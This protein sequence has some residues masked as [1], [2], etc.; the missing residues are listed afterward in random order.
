MKIG[1]WLTDT[2]NEEA[3]HCIVGAVVNVAFG[4]RNAIGLRTT[5]TRY[6]RQAS[7]YSAQFDLFWFAD[8][9]L[10]RGAN[11]HR[12]TVTCVVNNL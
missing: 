12:D 8:C 7:V 4:F 5:S 2:T 10:S 9:A 11:V 3:V 6:D 1:V